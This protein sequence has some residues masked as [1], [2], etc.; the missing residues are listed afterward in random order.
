VDKGNFLSSFLSLA[1]FNFL[2]VKS[3]WNIQFGMLCF[4]HYS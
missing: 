4:C 1:S 2:L 3:A